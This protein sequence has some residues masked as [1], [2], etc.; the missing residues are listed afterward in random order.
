MI[1][2]GKLKE[3]LEFYKVQ[4]VQSKSGYKNTEEVFMFSA[5]AE[6]TKNK[7]NFIVDADEIFHAVY[8][9]FRLRFRKEVDETNIV[10]YKDERFRITSLNPWEADGEMTIILEKINE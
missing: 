8:L 10:K 5:K 3:K 4:E 1:F 9:T 2:A 6:R 7:E